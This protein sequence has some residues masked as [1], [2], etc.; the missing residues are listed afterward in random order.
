MDSKSSIIVRPAK[1]E[2]CVEIIKLI[3]ELAEHEK[4]PNAPKINAK[5]TKLLKNRRFLMTV[6]V[7]GYLKTFYNSN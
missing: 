7:T 3:Q 1:K 4:M 6:R 2:D 5:G